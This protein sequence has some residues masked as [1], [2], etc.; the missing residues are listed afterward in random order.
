MPERILNVYATAPGKG[1]TYREPVYDCRNHEI[2]LWRVIPGE[3]MYYTTA[4][5]SHAVGPG[6]LA[7]A[8]PEE[9]HGIFNSGTEEMI[10]LSVLAPL[11]VEYAEA[12]GF[13]YP[14]D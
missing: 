7:F 9:V 4:D 2:H 10:I 13:N 3:G 1:H 8:S 11:P 5:E 6:D 12:P 14:T